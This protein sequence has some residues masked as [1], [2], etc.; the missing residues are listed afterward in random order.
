MFKFSVRGQRVGRIA[1]GLVLLAGAGLGA[2]HPERK[3]LAARREHVRGVPTF[4][5]SAESL[6]LHAA[7]VDAVLVGQAWHWVQPD[8]AS[9]EVGR[10]LRSGGVL[11]LMAGVSLLGLLFTYAFRVEGQGRTLERHHGADLH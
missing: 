9:A 4:V 11:G 5:G 1:F 7:S 8:L 2:L 10:V 3:R 6:P